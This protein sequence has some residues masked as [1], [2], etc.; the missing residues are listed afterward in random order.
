MPKYKKKS[1]IIINLKSFFY[2]YYSVRYFLHADLSLGFLRIDFVGFKLIE[3]PVRAQRKP[4]LSNIL[5]ILG[6]VA[7]YVY[8]CMFLMF[9]KKISSCCIFYMKRWLLIFHMYF[10]STS[11]V[12]FSFFGDFICSGRHSTFLI[13]IHED[14]HS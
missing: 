4:Q 2:F 7:K 8:T 12:M 11:K 14:Y 13:Y 10:N 9:K 3:T 1:V 5:R 6:K